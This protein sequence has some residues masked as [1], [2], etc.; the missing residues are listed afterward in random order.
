M[1]RIS[2]IFVSLFLLLFILSLTQVS[3]AECAHPNVDHSYKVYY[4]LGSYGHSIQTLCKCLSCG[5]TLSCHA[6]PGPTPSSP[7]EWTTQNTT[8]TSNGISDHT[9]TIHKQCACGATTQTSSTASHS[10]I[11]IGDAHGS[12]NI[13]NFYYKCI[14]RQTRTDSYYCEGDCRSTALKV[15]LKR[16]FD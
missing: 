13:H 16:T 7:H 9:V 5:T 3:L 10:F 8:Y 15:L 14:C 2:K 11:L 4:N 6:H 12:G 1:R